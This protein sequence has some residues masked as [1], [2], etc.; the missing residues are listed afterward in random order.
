MSMRATIF[1]QYKKPWA[2]LPFPKGNTVKGCG[3]GL[4]SVTHILIE[5]ERYEDYT[6]TT[7]RPFMVKYAVRNQGLQ[8]V[9]IPSTLKHYGMENV[10]EFGRAATMKQ[11]FE[12]CDKGGRLG[13]IL[14]YKQNAK[15][16]TIA[17][18]GPDGTVWTGG[19][20]FIA[21]T[22]YKVENGKH[23]FYMKDSG[24]RNHDGWYCYEKSM[25]GCVW[26]VW[27]CTIPK[28]APKTEPKK[29]TETN[30]ETYKGSIPAVDGGTRLINF[31][32]SQKGSYTS[33]TKHGK[34][35][36]KYANKFTKHFAGRGGID[37]KGQMPNV[38]GYI[39][40]YCTLFACYC[41][42]MIGEGAQIPFDTLNSKKNGYWWHA[43]SLMK[44]FKKKGMLC[45]VKDA[46]KGAIAFKGSGSPTHTAIFDKYED[47][48]V[49]TWDGNVGGGVTYNKRKASAFCGFVN[50]PLH[51]YFGEGAQGPD[52]LKWQKFLN[53]YNGKQVVAE[54]G[55]FGAYTDKY[56]KAFQKAMKLTDDGLVGSDTLAAAKKAERG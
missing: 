32:A 9:G 41:V 11:I 40:G 25:A 44:Y 4:C 43:P 17:A 48:Y 35:G 51:N 33:R 7:V 46:K 30:K 15:G 8:H 18:K 47:G 13:V 55:D 16:K 49:Y 20:H 19:G 21:F 45:S 29:E 34:D 28:A 14:F 37:S 54:D 53:W 2:S 52:V 38:Y 5:D 6:P 3:C 12:E 27:T 22:G 56:T 1:K 31:A 39:P 23:Y 42:E 24:G 36:K 10:K 50:L 26:K